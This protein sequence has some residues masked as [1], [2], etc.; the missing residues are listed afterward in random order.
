[1]ISVDNF[2]Y[3]LYKNLLE[4]TRFTASYFYP[5]GR[6]DVN[7]LQ[8]NW[9]KHS[10]VHNEYGNIALFYDQEPLII[11]QLPVQNIFALNNHSNCKLLANS[12]K[13]QLKKQICKNDNYLDWYYF[14]HG[15]AALSW[16]NDFK[17]LP[18]V[19]HQ[20]TKLFISLNRLHTNH[21]SYRL[22]LISEFIERDLLHKGQVS[23]P[24]H[25]HQFGS[26]QNELHSE[27]TLLPKHKLGKI[28]HNLSTL[29]ESLVVDKQ[30]VQGFLSADCG[31]SA[32]V[33]NQSA[34]WHVVSE[35][36]FYLD[37]LHL[38]E[39][40][41]KPITTRR[42]FILVGAKG[43]LEY[44]KSYG[45][46][47]FDK[48]IDES[49]DTEPD[50][51]KRIM[52]VVDQLERMSHLSHNQLRD[53]HRELQPILEYNYEHFYTDFKEVIT[54]ELIN[55]FRTCVGIYNNCRTDDRFINLN[56]I[57]FQQLKSI[58]LR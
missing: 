34:L 46:K 26:W 5:F 40:I 36:I 54:E 27:F 30:D 47:T 6:T 45:F 15:F 19:E 38:T 49:Y 18:N 14:Y 44:L 10:F 51:D 41:F 53:M 52:M 43:N 1:M 24:S 39:K 33:M 50:H 16:F 12:E 55:N 58:F 28:R 22:N 8:W 4:P 7:S 29:T 48:W 57:D 31:T 42:P 32:L 56:H 25:N 37:K 21:R 17:Y 11:D 23:F 13:S 9:E 35:T 2:Y 20:F 3:I